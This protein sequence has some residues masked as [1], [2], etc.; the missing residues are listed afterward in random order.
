AHALHW[1]QDGIEP[2]PGATEIYA[3]P[4][5]GRAEGFRFRRAWGVQFHPEVDPPALDGWYAAWSDLLEP[6]GTTLADARAADALHLPGQAALAA[7]I[8]G[9]FA[10]EVARGE[11]RAGEDAAG[12]EVRAGEGAAGDEI[13]AGEVA[14]ADARA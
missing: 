3:R 1:N 4:P 14:S 6:A 7:A 13:R 9:A 2:P 11:T 10:R 12:D 5:G 8:F